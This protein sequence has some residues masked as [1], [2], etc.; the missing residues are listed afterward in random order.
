MHAY[1]DVSFQTFYF[2]NVMHNQFDYV[3]GCFTLFLFFSSPPSNFLGHVC[4]RSSF[5]KNKKENQRDFLWN[6][7]QPAITVIVWRANFD[8]IS[9]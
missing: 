1:Y 6:F 7:F 3:T 4:I 2:K 8:N 9:K 5:K